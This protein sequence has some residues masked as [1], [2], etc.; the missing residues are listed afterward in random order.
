[1]PTDKWGNPIRVCLQWI[2]ELDGRALVACI[3]GGTILTI[4][5][6]LS[7]GGLTLPAMCIVFVLLG[8]RF[9]KAKTPHEESPACDEDGVVESEERK[10]ED[11]RSVGI[12]CLKIVA[13]LA[14]L[15]VISLC[16]FAPYSTL[17]IGIG[18]LGLGMLPALWIMFF[19][20]GKRLWKAETPHEASPSCDEDGVVEPEE[21]KKGDW[22]SVGIRCLRIVH[23]FV[24]LIVILL[25]VFAPYLTY[26]LV[27]A[28]LEE[29]YLAILPLFESIFG[30]PPLEM[31]L[32]ERF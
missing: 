8:K 10:K 6:G 4:F 9:W 3:I 25:C 17:S 27:F 23:G 31:E 18:I 16:V 21:R 28:L 12:R 29:I 14:F 2:T 22:R 26:S 15:I 19:L 30:P 13:G 1:M 20:L 5:W 7:L 32:G 24:F 11:R